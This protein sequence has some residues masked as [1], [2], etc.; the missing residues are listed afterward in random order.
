[1]EPAAE[2]LR[3]FSLDIL[4]R[5]HSIANRPTVATK[6]EL[7]EVGCRLFH[8]LLYQSPMLTLKCPDGLENLEAMLHVIRTFGDE[9]PPACQNTCEEAWPVFDIFLSKYGSEYDIAEHTTRVLRHGINLFGSAALP[10]ADSVMARMSVAFETTGFP[11]YLWIGGKV[12]GRF[13]NEESISLRASFQQ[14]YERSTNKVVAFLQVKL[15]GDIPDGMHRSPLE[16]IYMKL[17]ATFTQC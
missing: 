6:Q 17:M 9:L 12:I 13:G 16:R 5:V 2:S 10:I 1:M 14:L 15:P 11:S 4:A 8:F 7:M 3:T